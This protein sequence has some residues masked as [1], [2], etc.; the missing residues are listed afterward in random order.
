MLVMT[1]ELSGEESELE[2]PVEVGIAIP[3]TMGMLGL[4]FI[5][6]ALVISGL[7]PLSGFIAKFALVATA[8]NARPGAVPVSAWVFLAVLILSGLAAL[9]AMSRA[10]IR[11]FW[12]S[13]DWSV[14]HVRLIEMAPVVVLLLLCAMQ[15]IQAGPIM[16]YM[17]ATAQSL[18]TPRDYIRGV[19]GAR[20]D[21]PDR[22]MGG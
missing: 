4:A 10:G 16:R 7:P 20:V 18:H 11:A 5:G 12:A 9:I 17:Q 14:P 19:L 6:S 13:P 21:Q 8:I 2:G 22:R 15:T 1:R 3:A